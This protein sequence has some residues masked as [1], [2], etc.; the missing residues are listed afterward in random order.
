MGHVLAVNACSEVTTFGAHANRLVR[1]LLVTQRETTTLLVLRG[2]GQPEA[3]SFD[4]APSASD[5]PPL[6]FLLPLL[7]A[8]CATF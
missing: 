7:V 8:S 2:W 1:R 3:R 5:C 6:L 4:S